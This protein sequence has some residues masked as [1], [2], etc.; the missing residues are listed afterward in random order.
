[1]NP[2]RRPA[3]ADQ[4][5]AALVGPA[6]RMRLWAALGAIAV[7]A[8]AGWVGSRVMRDHEWRPKMRDAMP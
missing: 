6:H 1:M 4:V 8:G 2:A 3:D 5:A 7:L